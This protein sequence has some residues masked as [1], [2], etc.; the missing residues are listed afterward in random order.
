MTVYFTLRYVISLAL[1]I[2]F[3][4]RHGF[5]ILVGVQSIRVL[6]YHQVMHNTS[7]LLDLLCH[8]YSSQAS[9]LGRTY[10]CFPSLED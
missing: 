5:P 1:G 7:A 2:N 4:T 6:C 3:S 10:D 8:C 9:Q